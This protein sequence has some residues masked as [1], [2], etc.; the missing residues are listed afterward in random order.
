MNQHEDK[1]DRL[2]ALLERVQ[3]NASRRS[4]PPPEPLAASAFES[5]D[6]LTPQ[7]PG[8][9]LEDVSLEDVSLLELPVLEPL[10]PEP[11]PV[12]SSESGF[13]PLLEPIA[14]EPVIRGL[15]TFLD[16]PEP[17]IVGERMFTDTDDLE[18]IARLQPIADD[19]DAMV[20]E[21]EPLA[22]DDL[23]LEP[24]EPAPSEPPSPMTFGDEFVA[25]GA[26]PP[27]PEPVLAG[28]EAS[29][30]PE[31]EI[32]EEDF[33]EGDDIIEIPDGDFD[34]PI[35]EPIPESVRRRSQPPEPDPDPL[36]ELAPLSELPS[37]R[38]DDTFGAEVDR[39]E[40]RL[41]TPP[42]ESGSEP[43]TDEERATLSSIEPSPSP[44]F[45]P[46]P[47]FGSDAGPTI[48]QL[49]ATLDL[50]EPYAD[51]TL[52]LE[53]V[54]VNPQEDSGVLSQPEPLEAEPSSPRASEP[55]AMEVFPPL[56]GDSARY[57][58]A[59]RESGRH[60][61][62]RRSSPLPDTEPASFTPRED[63]EPRTFLEALDVS[64]KLEL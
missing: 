27:I 4:A 63:S 30:D 1:V 60:F 56:G 55:R 28:P 25:V 12:D 61:S 14:A 29:L 24:M 33:L 16:P 2:R 41:M 5:A 49:G 45:S 53:A 10:S 48:E 44:G 26:R 52:E 57:P 50:D 17:E 40:E 62:A 59:G 54:V 23:L 20:E 47:S 58:A 11:A 36:P 37:Q 9:S 46:G 38:L 34:E 18:P 15:P 19:I 51:E 39:T 8:V 42:P 32:F 7:V 43:V 3:Q 31:L 35:I 13:E 22:E 21:L 64:L 6:E